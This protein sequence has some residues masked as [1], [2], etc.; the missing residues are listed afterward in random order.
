M[1]HHYSGCNVCKMCRIGYTQMCMV[2]REGYG[3]SKNGGH[4]DYL[5]CPA[6]TCVPLPDEVSFEEGA[7]LACGSGTAFFGLKRLNLTGMDT[8]GHIRTGARWTQ[9]D[10]FRQGYGRPRAGR[11]RRP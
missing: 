5:L 7:A 10:Y 2:G 6:S 11:G 4:E 3:S 8:S 9:R 1:M